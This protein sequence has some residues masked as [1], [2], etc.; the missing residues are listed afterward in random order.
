MCVLEVEYRR[1]MCVLE[2]S[3]YFVRY[4]YLMEMS[5][6]GRAELE[7]GFPNR[8]TKVTIWL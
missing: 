2:G 3:D 7:A 5:H 4:A 8:K 1:P 6:T